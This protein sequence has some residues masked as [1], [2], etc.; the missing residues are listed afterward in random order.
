MLPALPLVRW[1]SKLSKLRHRFSQ[2]TAIL[3]EVEVLSAKDA[4]RGRLFTFA[5]MMRNRLP[6]MKSDALGSV[7][8]RVANLTHTPA[9]GQ[10]LGNQVVKW[11]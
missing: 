8:T 2:A 11:W 1:G 4:L 7:R 6:R 10:S 3:I 9:G 5:L